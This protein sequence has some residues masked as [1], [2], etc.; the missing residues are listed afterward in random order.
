MS[1][2]PGQRRRGGGRDQHADPTLEADALLNP[3]ALEAQLSRRL[4]EGSPAPEGAETEAATKEDAAS[5]PSKAAAP[6]T[7]D[8][9]ALSAVFASE[10][11]EAAKHQQ[12]AEAIFRSGGD[13]AV[14]EALRSE[15]AKTKKLESD[16]AQQKKKVEGAK[17]LQETKSVE[18]SKLA[19]QKEAIHAAC[20]KLIAERER[21][22]A[23][24]AETSAD[25][26]KRRQ[27][28]KEKFDKDVEGIIAKV[29]EQAAKKV[30]TVKENEELTKKFD[31]L[32]ASFD[33]MMD[34]KMSE[35]KSR[36]EET[37]TVVA[38]LQER[39]VLHDKLTQLAETRETEAEN[40]K[41]GTEAY[42][43]QAAIYEGRMSD[44]EGALQKSAEV[45]E[46]TARREAEY[47]TEIKRYEE[48]KIADVA[49]RKA[50]EE[51]LRKVKS[52]VRDMR[53]QLVQVEKTKATAEKRCRAAQEAIRKRQQQQQK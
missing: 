17:R 31:E 25:D 33:G 11:A 43:E 46:L 5:L 52:R 51:D 27:D 49:A 18:V 16:V 12:E 38:T 13:A 28:V 50:S 9:A 15:I 4:A 42:T 36:D 6:Q 19:Q 47:H 1:R 20:K 40:L 34:G 2:R 23:V 26:E 39:M 7:V 21:L 29:D 8:T 41:R 24:L 14:G 53:K 22:E 48:A 3:S 10:V 37:R 32:K 44:F 35:W 45:V 30:E